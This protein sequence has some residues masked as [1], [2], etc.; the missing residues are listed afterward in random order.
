MGAIKE[1]IEEI[2]EDLEGLGV[3]DE[4]RKKLVELG[5]NVELSHSIKGADLLLQGYK[6]ALKILEDALIFEA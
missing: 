2:K 3:A 1:K 6:M 5:Q 4:L